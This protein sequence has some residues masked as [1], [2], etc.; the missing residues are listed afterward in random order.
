MMAREMQQE[1][2]DKGQ[3]WP[4]QHRQHRTK[5]GY[6]D[7]DGPKQDEDDIHAK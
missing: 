5:D 4:W 7:A 2:A 6:D 1:Q 3:Q